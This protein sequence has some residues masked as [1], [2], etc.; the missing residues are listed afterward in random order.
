M[1][2]YSPVRDTEN[3][4]KSPAAQLDVRAKEA[5]KPRQAA[6]EIKS[7]AVVHIYTKSRL[8]V[9][10]YIYAYIA[11]PNGHLS[12]EPVR[13]V[14]HRRWVSARLLSLSRS[15]FHATQIEKV[16]SRGAAADQPLHSRMYY[17]TRYCARGVGVSPGER[18]RH[19]IV[20]IYIR[21][22]PASLVT[23]SQYRA[24]VGSI[25]IQFGMH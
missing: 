5:K 2:Y 15:A 1:Q 9:Y 11:G 3:W 23:L 22:R 7:L 19:Y 16:D 24:C 12:V 20:I 25:D 10:R 21:A 6:I 17:K 4:G 14:S 18:E 13:R 8:S